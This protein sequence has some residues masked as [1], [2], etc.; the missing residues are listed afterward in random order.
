M[1]LFFRLLPVL[2]M[3]VVDNGHLPKNIPFMVTE[4]LFS[5]KE[6]KTV[7]KYV[8]LDQSYYGQ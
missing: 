7:L 6:V 4:E 5:A 8:L 3:R 2:I 1:I